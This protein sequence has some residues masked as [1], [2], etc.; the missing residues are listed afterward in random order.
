LQKVLPTARG[1]SARI[2]LEQNT[3]KLRY[4]IGCLNDAQ[5]AE[6]VKACQASWARHKPLKGKLLNNAVVLQGPERQQPIKEL[7]DTLEFTQQAWL[8][9]VSVKLSVD[10]LRVLFAGGLSGFQEHFRETAGLVGTELGFPLVTEQPLVLTRD[11]KA[12]V[13]MLNKFREKASFPALK[14]HPKLMAVARA[15]AVT[16]AKEGK[17]E[18]D[19]LAKETP[20]RVREGGYKFKIG[21]VDFNIAAGEKMTIE[22]AFEHWTK[23][24]AK[25]DILIADFE[26]T[27]IGIAKNEETGI[28]YYYQVFSVPEPAKK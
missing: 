17:A 1:L 5:A 18:D 19:L 23:T 22:Q 9:E 7:T 11:E 20:Q 4:G 8:A 12:L 25:H 15:H 2:S 21:K 26:E 27:G 16:M 13:D 14:V 3:V 6:L 28:V 24:V 10:P